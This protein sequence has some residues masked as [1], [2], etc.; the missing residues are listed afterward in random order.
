MYPRSKHFYISPNSQYLLSFPVPLSVIVK[1]L[2]PIKPSVSVKQLVLN[3]TLL[4]V[5]PSIKTSV[6]TSVLVK[7]LF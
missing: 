4:L 6:K 1:L 3:K 2:L 7:P 5:K